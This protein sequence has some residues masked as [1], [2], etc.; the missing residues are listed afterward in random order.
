MDLT[1]ENTKPTGNFIKG[2][3]PK[4]WFSVFLHLSSRALALFKPSKEVDFIDEILDHRNEAPKKK[5]S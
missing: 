1:N 2:L 3:L 5:A 4:R